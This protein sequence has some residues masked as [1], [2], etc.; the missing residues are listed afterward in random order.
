[1]HASIAAAIVV[2]LALLAGCAKP[3]HDGFNYGHTIVKC[4]QAGRC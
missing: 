4:T 1:M 3:S 2:A